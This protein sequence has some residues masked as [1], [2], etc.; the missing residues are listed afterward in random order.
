MELPHDNANLPQADNSGATMD[1][2]EH[3]QTSKTEPISTDLLFSL[4][5]E[6]LLPIFSLVGVENFRR[7]VRRLAVCKEWYAYARPILLGNLRLWQSEDLLSMLRAT[8]GG[9]GL[10][11]AQQMT[12]HIDID[13]GMTL[14]HSG[15]LSASPLERLASRLR[16]FAA[17][18]MLVIR[19]TGWYPYYQRHLRNRVISSFTTIQQLTSLEIDLDYVDLQQDDVH[20]CSSI[21]QRIPTIKRL[22]CRLPCIC[23]DLLEAPPGDLEELIISIAS[24]YAF[25]TRQCFADLD[26]NEGE[27][28]AP[29]EARLVQFVASMRGPK[30]VRLVYCSQKI[31]MTYAFDAIRKRRLALGPDPAWDADGVLLPEDWDGNEESEEDEDCESE[32]GED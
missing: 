25:Y 9:S 11:A 17:L 31:D 23:N 24:P 10:A 8:E 13:V 4:P 15:P 16:V 2:M 21:S 30:M 14:W 32:E 12:K 22:R 5:P 18:R 7:D 20:L 6:L 27:H 29:L 1:I 28:R 26:L 19:S 3:P